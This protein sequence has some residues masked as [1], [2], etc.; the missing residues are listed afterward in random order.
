LRTVRALTPRRCASSGPFQSRRVFPAMEVPEL[1]A[2]D[3]Q[4]FF[5]KLD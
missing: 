3:I 2:G 4:E 1:L 5:A